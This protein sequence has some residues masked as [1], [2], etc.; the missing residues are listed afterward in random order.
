MVIYDEDK[1]FYYECLQKYDEDEEI[2]PL[3]AFFKYET[4]KTWT[5]QVEM[6]EGVAKKRKTLLQLDNQSGEGL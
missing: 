1:S 4:E 3:E 5:N 2:A 6:S